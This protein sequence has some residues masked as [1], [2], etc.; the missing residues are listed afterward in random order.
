METSGD[1]ITVGGIVTVQPEVVAAGEVVSGIG[2][3]INAVVDLIDGK[4]LLPTV[5][6]VGVGMIFG[7]LSNKGIEATQKV[8]GKEYVESGA[9]KVSEAIIEGTTKAGEIITNELIVPE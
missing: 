1:V 4:S 6:I 5:A 8:A 3:T 2:I 9:N 7:S